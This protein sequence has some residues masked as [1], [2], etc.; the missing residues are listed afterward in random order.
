MLPDT[1]ITSFPSAGPLTG[2]EITVAVQNGRS[3]KIEISQLASV[4]FPTQTL[5]TLNQETSL[6]A[7]RQL[8]FAEPIYATDNGPQNTYS[9]RLSDSLTNLNNL[10]TDGYLYKTGSGFSAV[11]SA[12]G[13]LPLGGATNYV[14]GKTSPADNAIGWLSPYDT[15]PQP[16]VFYPEQFGAYGD[17]VGSHDGV[18]SGASFDQFSS[19][20]F[21]FTDDYVGAS[22]W[23]D[24]TLRTITGV[25]SGVATFTPPH[26]GTATNQ[27]WLAGHDDTV[28]IQA[29]LTAA[30]DVQG[31]FAETA[32]GTNG[33]IISGGVCVL[34]AG[35][36]YIVSNSQ[37][38]YNA[39]RLSALIVYRRTDFVGSGMV[40]SR[41][42]LCLA[43]NSYGHMIANSNPG[44]AYTDFV[45]IGRISLFGYQEWSPNAL[46]GI[47]WHVAFDG[48]DKVD[49]FNRFYDIDC[50]RMKQDGFYFQ[51]RGELIVE[52]CLSSNSG[53]YGYYFN[54]QVDYKVNNCNAGGSSKTGFRIYSSGAGHY[55]NCKSFY[56]GSGGAA[57][58]ADCCNWYINADQMRNGGA[59]FTQC[60]GQESRGSSWV[61]DNAG[62]CTLDACQG[63]DPARAG[64][65][66]GTLPTVRAGFHL[67]SAGCC[68]NTFIGCIAA[69]S[70][71]LYNATNNWGLAT[72]AV[73]IEGV[74]ANGAGPQSNRGTIYTFTPVINPAGG[75]DQGIQYRSG[76]GARGGAGFTNGRHTYLYVDG[77]VNQ[78]FV[79]MQVKALVATP[80]T[81]L[82]ILTW[83]NWFNGGSPI[84]D[85]VVEYKLSTEPTVWT[86]WSHAI[87]G[88]TTTVTITGLTDNLSY[89]FRVSSVNSIGTGAVSATATTTPSS[90]LSVLIPSVCMDITTA[91]A[92][93]YSGAGQTWSNLITS[94]ADGQAQTAYDFYLGADGS[95][96][97]NDPT[98]NGTPGTGAAYFSVDGGDFFT[99]KN[100]NTPLLRDAHKTT[101]GS[102][103]SVAMVAKITTR[104]SGANP[105]LIMGTGGA[106]LTNHGFAVKNG[107]ISSNVNKIS[108]AAA[109]GTYVAAGDYSSIPDISDSTYKLLVFTYAP[110]TAR[111]SKCYSNDSTPYTQTV[112]FYTDTTDASLPLQIF[113]GGTGDDSNFPP[114]LSGSQIKSASLYNGVLTDAQ[115]TVLKLFYEARHGI[116]L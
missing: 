84:T 103:W 3:V 27:L 48:Y 51:G 81:T 22:L 75:Y 52:N 92:G 68:Q 98:F 73:Y 115:V 19:A 112:S 69:P 25:S 86:T 53:R 85:A 113:A 7:S 110:S 4:G 63:L 56:S 114:V 109:N 26:S 32:G 11:S 101:G 43:P 91:D 45:S 102:T 35:K 57:V 99:I 70:V 90:T 12:T 49:P 17:A 50:F 62:F 77:L 59:H 82:V 29:A 10:S 47:H 78:A 54:G 72:D 5:F 96:G 58:D 6:P 93:S 95:V 60:E 20:A 44:I 9:V 16:N 36:A 14:L 71:A 83:Q 8:T 79:P 34:R 21:S 116:V 31:E 76:Y 40:A 67:K 74:D 46:N 41:S 107:L 39:G 106:V 66:S 37:T 88:T 104:S 13:G 65:N 87:L 108:F 23:F 80:S 94:P 61:I 97:T 105:N 38:S 42:A 18:I 15:T 89:D 24:T 55:V 2:D 64:L 1:K 33:L 100:G 28:A 30:R 111:A